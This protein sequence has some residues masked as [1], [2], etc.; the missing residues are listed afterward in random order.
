MDADVL[1]NPSQPVTDLTARTEANAVDEVRASYEVERVAI[2][3]RWTRC[4]APDGLEAQA[5]HRIRRQSRLRGQR[6]KRQQN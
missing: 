6:M 3:A 1:V 5:L 2:E 4:I